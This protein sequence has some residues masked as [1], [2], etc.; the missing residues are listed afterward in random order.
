[1]VVL[2][3]KK[4]RE[5]L[6]VNS[7]MLDKMVDEQPGLVW[8]YGELQAKAEDKVRKMKLG[9]DTVEAKIK[10]GLYDMPKKITVDQVEAEI[11]TNILYINA[12]KNLNDAQADLDIY[13]LITNDLNFHKSASIDNKV[14]MW[15]KERFPDV[16]QNPNM[17]LYRKFE[18]A[19]VQDITEKVKQRIVKFPGKV[20]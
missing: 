20:R 17:S 9:L 16:N 10:K 8:Y 4:L 6:T 11:R 2:D 3:K 1:M 12:R 18:T 19:K 7:T 5:D 14:K 15:L 13:N